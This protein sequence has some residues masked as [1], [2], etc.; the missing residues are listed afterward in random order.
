MSD[1]SWGVEFEKDEALKAFVYE[2]IREKL[3]SLGSIDED[4]IDNIV[5]YQPFTQNHHDQ[6]LQLDETWS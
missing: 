2:R 5:K 4:Y 1:K 3:T 6:Y